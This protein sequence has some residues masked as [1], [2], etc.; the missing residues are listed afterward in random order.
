MKE[1]VKRILDL[2]RAGKL[3]LEDAA[4]LLA[5]LNARLALTDS[6]RELVASLLAREE[7][8]TAQVAE[9]LL[10][11]RGLKD[12]APGPTPPRPPQP[13]RRPQ[14]T[15][16]GQRVG[17]LEDL[18]ERIAARLENVAA[19]FAARAEHWGEEFGEKAGRWGEDVDIKVNRLAD[20]FERAVQHTV[21]DT[22]GRGAQPG[23]RSGSSGR[24][25][26]IQV[27]SEDG[28]EYSANIPVSLAPH[29][30]KLIPPHG[31]RALEKAGFTVEALQLIIEADPPPGPII[32]AED[33]DGNEV[34]ISIK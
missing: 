10:L 25:L 15:I 19:Q 24:I 1:K 27:E 13:P 17:G 18:G 26:R 33:Q 12:S 8:D 7:L 4:P 2:V 20:D 23:V 31:I 6:D 34:H 21:F 11:L 14:V 32:E 28:D 3:S 9:H 16:G 22:P 29:L 30:H 5:A